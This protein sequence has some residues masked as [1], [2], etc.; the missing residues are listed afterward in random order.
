M[1][2]WLASQAIADKAAWLDCRA[3]GYFFD[4]PS[5][6]LE[7]QSRTLEESTT[8]RPWLDVRHDEWWVERS[9]NFSVPH[10]SLLL[11][12][13]PKPGETPEAFARR[14]E[15]TRTQVLQ[16]GGELLSD[17][18]T[19]SRGRHLEFFIIDWAMLSAQRVRELRLLLIE[20]YGADRAKATPR[21]MILIPGMANPKTGK[22]KI[23]VIL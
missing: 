10:T 21:C 23:E 9:N 20:H 6:T 7:V 16:D 3:N 14:I 8:W 19:G 2:R 1:R 12:I 22:R 4:G 13:D 17:C 15:L 5:G 18:W 11:D